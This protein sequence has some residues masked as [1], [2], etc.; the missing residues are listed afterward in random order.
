MQEDFADNP[1]A[2]A[3]IQLM[4]LGARDDGWHTD[5]GCSMEVRVTHQPQ[6]TLHQKPRSFYVGNLCTLKYNVRHRE[7]CKDTFD[8]AAV[9]AK[10]DAEDL[11]PAGTPEG[12]QRLQIAV[13]IRSDVF[14]GAKARAINP[15]PRPEELFHVVNDV[16][17]RHLAAVPVALPDL[18]DVL[19]E[20]ARAEFTK[21]FRD[22]GGLSDGCSIAGLQQSPKH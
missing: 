16:V 3:S 17:A 20:V 18:T 12:D 2:Y 5:G 13:M 22:S 15:T 19:A 7:E 21:A 11:A 1:F 4:Q 9:T 6:V 14:R 10:G 8:G